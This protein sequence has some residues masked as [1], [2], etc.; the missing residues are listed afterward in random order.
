MGLGKLE[1]LP[2]CTS[3]LV[4][5]WAPA[6]VCR[7]GPVQKKSRLYK[8]NERKARFVT[9]LPAAARRKCLVLA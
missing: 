4:L 2:N 1:E 6:I 5:G 9:K 7:E 8:E 3:S